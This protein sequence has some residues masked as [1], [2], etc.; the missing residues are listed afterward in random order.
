MTEQRGS[1]NEMPLATAVPER[2]FVHRPS[3]RLDVG[4]AAEVRDVL[5][6]GSGPGRE[7]V[8]DLSAVTGFDAA[9]LEALVR[10][11]RCTWRS[12]GS[13]RIIDPCPHLATML[14]LT[15]VVRMVPLEHTGAARSGRAA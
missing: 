11:V 12:G 3:G 14:S 7:V 5:A 2:R 9:G 1:D 8:V 13:M 15:G 4:T 10:A 6:H